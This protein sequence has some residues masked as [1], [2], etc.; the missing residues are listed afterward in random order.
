MTGELH[1]AVC[2]RCGNDPSGS[3]D[4]LTGHRVERGAMGNLVIRARRKGAAASAAT[5]V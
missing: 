4:T 3:V 1:Y 5:T 2:L